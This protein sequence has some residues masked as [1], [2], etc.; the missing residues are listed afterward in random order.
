MTQPL[1]GL[2]VLD[3][4]R[5]VSGPYCTQMLADHG[6]DVIKVE[7][8]GGDETRRFGPPFAG[9]DATYFLSIN[10]GKR[11]IAVD[12][13]TEQ[14]L[15]LV[16][17]LAARADVVVENFRPG[18]AERL[19]VGPKA[20][21]V[22]D[23]KLIY[24]SISGYG[25]EGVAPFNQLPGYDLILQGVGGIA[26]LTGPVDGLPHKI[27]ASL[28]DII[29]ALNAYGGLMTALYER[30]RTGLGR[31]LDVS[32]FDGQVSA[33][34]YHATAQLNGGHASRRHGNAHASLCP[35]E[36]FEVRG[37]YL[38]IAC[39]NDRQFR[40][41][42]DVL[43]LSELKDDARFASNAVRVAHRD[44]LLG[45]L[46][47]KLVES[48]TDTW[49]ARF[50]DAGIPCGPIARV[51]DVLSHPQVA[52]RGLILEH[53]SGDDGLVRTVASATGFPAGDQQSRCPPRLGEHGIEVVREELGY[54]EAQIA[55]LIEAGAL[56]HASR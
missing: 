46:Q 31:H 43:Q 29:A 33:L 18:V 54:D 34:M 9:D 26:S 42:C 52:A 39:A 10:R 30:E 38:N 1:Q 21:C 41:L 49:M 36:L 32:M 11:S 3:L 23:P 37:G 5:V 47:P 35:Y 50:A 8:P 14:G 25:H 28:A 51:E 19:G 13:K 56:C 15:K 20:L 27:G 6:A 12:L 55:K 17:D 4:S 53:P 22:R 24:C 7:P 45:Y 44:E 40:A 2:R 16:L 48:D